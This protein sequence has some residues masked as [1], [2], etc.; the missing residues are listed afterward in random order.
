MNDLIVRER[1]AP[2]IGIGTSGEWA[3]SAEALAAAQLD[4]EV[5]Q[6]QLHWHLDDDGVVYD[7]DAPMYGNVRNTDDKLL[8]CVTPQ[9]RILQN[10][11]AFSLL[12][13]FVQN[14]DGSITHAGMTE[15]GLVFMVAEL[16]TRGIGGEEYQVNLMATNSFNAKYPCQIIMTPVRIICQNMYRGLVKDRIFLAKHTLQADDRLRQIASGD[17]VDNTV[18]AFSAI[19][20]NTQAKE[21]SAE[22]LMRLIAMLFPYPK[23]GP[24]EELFRAR[25]D[26]SR[27][28][29]M[30]RYYD[31]PDNRSHQGTAF[32]FV[33]AYMDY[34]SHRDPVR[35][36]S[37]P[38]A[39]RRLQG[40][41]S[42]LD[43]D[44]SVI[45]RA[46]D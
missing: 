9:Y 32:G 6:E 26:A 41:V 10:C 1:R 40:I 46:I 11:N 3:S 14:N 19:V 7:M 39:D 43:I 33:N 16:S 20:E 24:R 8:G 44:R 5:R 27:E 23:E 22:Q 34:L 29:F 35:N 21:M 18:N 38:W 28:Q 12:D 30:D 4:F 45:R 37:M 2:W 13:P 25:V 31:A 15:D 17:V 42:G 36:T